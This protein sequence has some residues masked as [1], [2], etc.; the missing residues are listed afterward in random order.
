MRTI[1]E[2]IVDKKEFIK[3]EIDSLAKKPKL[4]IVQV[5]DDP[6]SNAYIRGKLK[7]SAEVGFDSELIKLSE[8]TS[9]KDLLDLVEKLNHD[10]SVT[11]FI[12]QMPLPKGID[13]EKVKRAV[14]PSK[15]VDGFNPLSDLN[16]ATP[17]GIVTYL[18]DEGFSFKGKNA[19]VLGRSNIVGRPMARLLLD[20]SMNVTVIHSKTSEEDKRLYLKNADLIVTAVGKIGVLSNDYE[21]KKDAVVIDVGINR[22][23]DGKLHGDA[24]PEL[25]VGFQTPVPGGVG[26]LTRL[27][28][29]LNL[30]KVS[31]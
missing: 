24:L 28:L 30:L 31:K 26:L 16:P 7:D 23:D 12:V 19:V 9:E 13:E 14:T 2:Y 10:D 3:N 27:A 4:V 22:G 6:A 8:T 20:E 5:N 25:N 29:L 15:D 18:K 11:G 21:Y 1:K 17:Q